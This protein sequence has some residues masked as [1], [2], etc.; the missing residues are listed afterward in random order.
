MLGARGRLGP[1]GAQVRWG[2]LP[3]WLLGAGLL[4]GAVMGSYSLRPLQMLYS[5]LKVPLLVTVSG[6][7]CLPNLFVLNT[8]LGLRQ[9]LAAVLRGAALA[10]GTVSISLAALAPITVIA[11]LSLSDYADAVVFNGLVFFA[12]AI[13]G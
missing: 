10:Q 1:G 11:Y 2:V 12:A 7:I 3:I 13:A 4:Y 8:L 5:A 9:D 6:L